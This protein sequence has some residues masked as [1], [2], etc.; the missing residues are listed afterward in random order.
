MTNTLSRMPAG[1]LH[2]DV[3]EDADGFVRHVWRPATAAEARALAHPV[4][5][6][7]H[8]REATRLFGYDRDAF[9]ARQYPRYRKKNAAPRARAFV[10]QAMKGE[11]RLFYDG[12]GFS[13]DRKPVTFKTELAAYEYARGILTRYPR[14]RLALAVREMSAPAAPRRENPKKR[15]RKNPSG[16]TPTHHEKMEWARMA[17]W[18]TKAGHRELGHRYSAA[19]SIGHGKTLSLA[20]YDALQGP[21]RQWLNTNKFPPRREN[22]RKRPRKNPSVRDG[23]AQASERL[24]NFSGHK[25]TEVMRIQER[26]TKTGLVIGTLD[27]LLYTTVRDNKTEG[28]I[29][30][31]RRKSRPLLAASSDGK[32]LKIVGGRFEFT[33]AGIEDR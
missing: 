33:E 32:S 11:T 23:L 8:E 7:Q 18:A 20:A 13:D 21:Y 10:I 16:I 3:L 22:P 5:V 27:G 4:S 1:T 19:A 15:R 9:L 28:Y 30:R 2:C 25:P 12:K 31:F 24:Q 17:G 26:N 6:E 14:A 29:H